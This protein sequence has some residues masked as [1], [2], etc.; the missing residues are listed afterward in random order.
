MAWSFGHSLTVILALLIGV[1]GGWI[2]R[3]RR[4][5]QKSEQATVDGAAVAPAAVLAAPAP[6]AVTDPGPAVATIDPAPN[7]V[8]DETVTDPLARP[9]DTTAPDDAALAVTTDA[10]PASDVDPADMALTDGPAP[11]VAPRPAPE[12]ERLD[13]A[14]AGESLEPAA[15]TPDSEPATGSAVADEPVPARTPR[16]DTGFSASLAAEPFGALVPATDSEEGTRAHVEPG[17]EASTDV[18]PAVDTRAGAGPDV[19]ATD[20]ATAAPNLAAGPPAAPIEAASADGPTTD[21]AVAGATPATEEAKDDERAEAPAAAT[22]RSTVATPPVRPVAATSVEV[23]DFRRIQG[24]G[25][26]MAAALQAAGVRTYQ[27]LADL[28]ETALRDLI[29]GAGLR[30]APG[31]ATWPQQARVLASAPDEAAAALPAHTGTNEA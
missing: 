17:P 20:A 1:A 29:R 19:K 15:V 6:A 8:A 26:K 4:D 27:Q 24:I 23:D 21:A 28:D 25:P 12:A 5:A 2:L 11:V 18:E 7:E 22:R 13:A 10:A 31:L 30:A 9:D 14:G 3:G 16:T